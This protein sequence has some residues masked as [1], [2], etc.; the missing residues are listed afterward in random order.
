[1]G[2]ILKREAPQGF[3]S[4]KETLFSVGR[5]AAMLKITDADLARA[6]KEAR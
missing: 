4:E 1:L 2:T 6:T 3:V 5:V